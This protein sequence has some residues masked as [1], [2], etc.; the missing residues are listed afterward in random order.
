MKEEGSFLKNMLKIPFYWARGLLCLFLFVISTAIMFFCFFICWGVCS[1]PYIKKARYPIVRFLNVLWLK[2]NHFV[3]FHLTGI[4][5]ELDI[6]GDFRK[7]G[8]YIIVANHVSWAD[9]FC[10]LGLVGLK[11]PLV[12][13]FM[14]SAFRWVPFMGQAA[15]LMNMP[16]VKSFSVADMRKTPGFRKRYVSDLVASCKVLSNR[17]SSLL[18]YPEGG[19]YTTKTSKN[20][21][22]QFSF[23]LA[24]SHLAVELAAQVYS[25]NSPRLVDVSIAYEGDLQKVNLWRVF[26]G[27]VSRIAIKIREHPISEDLLTEGSKVLWSK[28]L[29]ELWEEKDRFIVAAHKRWEES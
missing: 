24:P 22:G 6:K 8:W 20:K 7:D 28:R 10:V 21:K 12:R 26:T 29:F 2:I 25:K 15:I 9:T 11:V 16:I 18:V 13:M 4:S 3:F 17:P 1:L 27:K 23:L 14:K 19:R 5:F